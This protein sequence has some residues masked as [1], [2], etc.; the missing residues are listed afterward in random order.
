MFL[1]HS[2]AYWFGGRTCD[3]SVIDSPFIEYHRVN[4]FRVNK[5]LEEIVDDLFDDAVGVCGHLTA[6]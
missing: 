5:C 6:V 3:L 4:K 1:S 2:L